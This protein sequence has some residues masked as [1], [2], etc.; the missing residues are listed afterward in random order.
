M[1]FLS[2]RAFH[3][4]AIRQA[5]FLGTRIVPRHTHRISSPSSAFSQQFHAFNASQV[6]KLWAIPAFHNSELPPSPRNSER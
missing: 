4:L 2:F 6:R 1:E 3:V 5:P